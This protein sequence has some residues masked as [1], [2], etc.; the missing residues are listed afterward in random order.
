MVDL[1]LLSKPQQIILTSLFLELNRF[2][3]SEK[4]LIVGDVFVVV[5]EKELVNSST[6]KFLFALQ[7]FQPRINTIT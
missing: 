3:T 5:F 4:M 7:P 2:H 6:N 1:P